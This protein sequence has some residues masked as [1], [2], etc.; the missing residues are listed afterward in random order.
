[1]ADHTIIFRVHA[2][3]QMFH[4]GLS[5]VDVRDV[6]EHG[7]VIEDYPNDLP[8]PARLMLGWV[9]DGRPRLPLHVVASYD[10]QSSTIF[11]VTVYEP[12][13]ARWQP[14]FRKRRIA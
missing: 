12:T 10:H 3:Q 1:M 5:E 2:I 9:G 4:R 8:Y 14:G 11:V 7:E 6:L 13:I